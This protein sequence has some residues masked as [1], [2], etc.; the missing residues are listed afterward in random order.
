MLDEGAVEAAGKPAASGGVGAPAPALAARH[1][2]RV[3]MV[4]AAFPPTGGPGV[5]R[6]A[7]FAKYLPTFG[8]QPIVWTLPPLDDLPEDHTLAAELPPEVVV[9][10]VGGGS[11]ARALRRAVR[12]LVRGGS[13]GGRIGR[14][15]EWRLTRWMAREP[16][17]DDCVYWAKSGVRA[18]ARLVARERIN[19]IYS[20]F[21]P[22]SDHLLGMWLKRRTGRPWVADF[23]D[24]WTDDYRYHEPSPRRREAHRRL[25]QEILETADVVL[26]V[27]P[28]QTEILADRVPHQRHKFVTITNG[29]DPADFAAPLPEPRGGGRFTLAHVGR[30]D[31]NRVSNALLA[32]LRAFA[33]HLGSRRGRVVLR[34]VGHAGDEVRQKLQ[35]TSL[36]CEFTG[37]VAHATAIAEMR[38][39]DALLLCVH[40]GPNADSVIL[41]KLFEYLAAGRPILCLGPARGQCATIVR[42]H[43][44]GLVVPFDRVTPV[45][46]ALQTLYRAAASG[47]PLPGAA[48]ERLTAYSRPDLTRRLAMILDHLAAGLPLSGCHATHERSAAR[49]A[50]D[51]EPVN[52]DALGRPA[53]HEVGMV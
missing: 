23:R 16:L 5:Q 12:G 47:R 36:P 29:F 43:N 46:D 11:W 10:R 45:T 34:I 3:L 21:S 50:S 41:G 31:R 27:T 32:G 37:E 6:P 7:K 1:A 51:V 9:H 24:L 20:T 44:A 4:A 38:S 39:A 26:G 17:P 25:E 2:R 13:A 52:A 33:D 22:P 14:A 15:L 40:D 8:W 35:R 30:L 28:R 19:A 53:V 49:R 48:L 42:G 18:A